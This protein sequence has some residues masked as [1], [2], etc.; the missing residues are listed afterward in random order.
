MI[1][2]IRILL[3]NTGKIL[4]FVICAS[5]CVSYC[6]CLYALIAKDYIVYGDSV[7]LNKP[8]SW[9]VG[10]W[11]EYKIQLLIVLTILSIAIKTCIYNKLAILYAY[12]NLLEKDY[13][14]RVELYEDIICIIVM[15]N[16]IISGYFAYKGFMLYLKRNKTKNNNI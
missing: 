7:V 12:I 13:Y 16:V 11:F 4:P 9:C 10:E 6:E 15:I 5:V 8:I 1:N 3:I 14:E 2:R